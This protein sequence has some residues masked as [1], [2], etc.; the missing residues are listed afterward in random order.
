MSLKNILS[1]ASSN[2]KY[3]TLLE[4]IWQYLFRAM[5]VFIIT[6][7]V[8][9][10]LEL[11]PREKYPKYEKER[12]LQKCLVV[13]LLIMWRTEHLCLWKLCF[14]FL[15]FPRLKRIRKKYKSSTTGKLLDV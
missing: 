4:S 3:R 12:N 1:Y 14:I 8:I 6:D 2:V 7:P 9:P 11:Y 5:E 10:F 15:R 13:T